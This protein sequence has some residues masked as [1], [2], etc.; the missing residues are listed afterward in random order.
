M[1]VTGPTASAISQSANPTPPDI[2]GLIGLEATSIFGLGSAVLLGVGESYVRLPANVAAEVRAGAPLRKL[3][4]NN[5]KIDG[6]K[7]RP[8]SDEA[9]QDLRYLAGTSASSARF[10]DYVGD[11][12]GITVTRR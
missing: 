11:A 8:M 6:A 4:T 12:K 3:R 7:L 9:S 5:V 1:I 10:Y 2:G